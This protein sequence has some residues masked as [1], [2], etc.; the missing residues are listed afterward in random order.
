M[1]KLHTYLAPGCNV[2]VTFWEK[3]R[4]RS[5]SSAL[6][7]AGHGAKRL[8]HRSPPYPHRIMPDNA[9]RASPRKTAD[10]YT[11][12]CTLRPRPS[13][14]RNEKAHMRTDCEALPPYFFTAP[15]GD[16]LSTITATTMSTAPPASDIQGLP[17]K[18][19][20]T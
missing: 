11:S 7:L 19:A 5:E 2:A 8:R 1:R 10:E 18:P 6:R 12:A 3:N 4:M 13:R 17:V 9:N 20:T 15:Y 16:I 14:G